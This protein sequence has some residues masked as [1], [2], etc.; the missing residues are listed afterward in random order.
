M[1]R[2]E[3]CGGLLR[4]INGELLPDDAPPV[5]ANTNLFGGDVLNS[6]RLI[7][8]L[9][10]VEDALDRTIPDEDIVMHR[11]ATVNDI[12]RSFWPEGAP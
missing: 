8:L 5:H 10:F 3:F 9:A 2:D 4:F 1:T 6:L 12:A 7:H 11:F